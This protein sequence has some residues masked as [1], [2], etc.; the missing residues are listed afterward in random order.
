[1]IFRPRFI[2]LLEFGTRGKSKLSYE[3]D[4]T[5]RCSVNTNGAGLA[6][7]MSVRTSSSK[8][9]E[10]PCVHDLNSLFPG[11]IALLLLY[12]NIDS[13]NLSFTEGITIQY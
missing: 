3:F 10:G 13:A 8:M 7:L 4:L 11:F 5:V 9:N 6:Q 1:M 2:F 12:I